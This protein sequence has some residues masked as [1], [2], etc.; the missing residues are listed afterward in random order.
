MGYSVPGALGAKLACPDRPVVALAGNGAF[1][2]TGLEL[3]T[4]R[5]QDVGA[6]IFVLR[7]REL[8]QIAQFQGTALNRKVASVLPEYDL[9][10]LA[11]AMGVSFMRIDNDEEVADV[12]RGAQE[13]AR[14]GMPVLVDVAIDYSTKT[15]FTKGVVRANLHRLPLRDRLRFIGRALTRKIS[16]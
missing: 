15:Y 10:C 12:V 5:A 7:D 4:A 13:E 2:M 9:E 11:Q 3:I 14:G 16:G 6:M 1:L 8:A